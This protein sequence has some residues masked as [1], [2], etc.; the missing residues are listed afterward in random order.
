MKNKS[1]SD[2]TGTRFIRLIKSGFQGCCCQPELEP[3]QESSPFSFPA[4][5][6][7]EVTNLNKN[8]RSCR[9]FVVQSISRG[10]L[11]PIH[12]RGNFKSITPTQK[13]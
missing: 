1:K 2:P 5:H 8:S 9:A 7:V 6:A 4:H 12:Q 3:S 10:S 11:R 13:S